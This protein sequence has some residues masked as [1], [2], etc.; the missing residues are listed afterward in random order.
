M[1]R[2]GNGLAGSRFDDWLERP[3]APRL[4]YDLLAE[5]PRYFD[6]SLVKALEADICE[7]AEA[8]R[9]IDRAR[10]RQARVSIQ[11]S[12]DR[13]RS[14]Y[15][16]A[17]VDGDRVGFWLSM[18]TPPAPEE[19]KATLRRA[20]M[21]P[22]PWDGARA[23]SPNEVI[24]GFPIDLGLCAWPAPD[25][26]LFPE[27]R[28]APLS[29]DN[30]TWVHGLDVDV[31]LPALFVRRGDDSFAPRYDVGVNL[32]GAKCVFVCRARSVFAPAR[33][34]PLEV[35]ALVGVNAFELDLRRK[36][37]RRWLKQ[38]ARVEVSSGSKSSLI[39]PPPL[40]PSLALYQKGD[41]IGA[42]AQDEHGARLFLI[43]GRACKSKGVIEVRGLG[44]S[45]RV[46]EDSRYDL[47]TM[48]LEEAS[49][50]RA[51][52]LAPLS[53]GE[54]SM[55]IE[56][57]LPLSGLSLHVRLSCEALRCS[58]LVPVAALPACLDCNAW[59]WDNLSAEEAKT[60]RAD[61]NARH[62][63]NVTASIAGLSEASWML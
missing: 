27:L 17:A 24:G 39:A 46:E 51:K 43:D 45:Y 7:Y 23:A 25:T 50:A 9:M 60:L 18:S 15:L 21:M 61:I 13:G 30:S 40:N 28:S 58:Y 32:Q 16:L 2:H 38:H 8:S 41:A 29:Q 33:A 3:C 1:K 44:L 31:S 34:R 4:V 36:A 55:R 37:H 6:P 42:R 12:E 47:A 56:G 52:A 20:F 19:L 26:A 10:A 11:R 48:H 63:V 62:V 57:P 22:R 14:A 54:V 49:G 5:A 59:L 53:R 35:G